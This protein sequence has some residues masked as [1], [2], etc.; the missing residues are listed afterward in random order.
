MTGATANLAAQVLLDRLN[1]S[2]GEIDGRLGRNL[3][4]ALRAFQKS[5]QL[6]ESGKPDPVTLGALIQDTQVAVLLPYRITAE[7]AAG[8]FVPIPTKVAEQAKL[9][10][11]GY[12]SLE[13]AL[14]ERFHCSPALLR[15]LNRG[16]T[17]ASGALIRVPNVP[18]PPAEKAAVPAARVLVSKES[19]L[20]QAFDADGKLLFLAPV[21]SGSE[22]DPLP[23]GSWKVKGV[24]RNP[25]FHYN[26]KLFWDAK[27]TDVK[28]TLPAG[29]NNPVGVVWIE[30]SKE[31]YGLHGTPE[32]GRIGHT[33]SHG[34]VRLT[35]WD[36][37]RLASLV[38]PGTPV[39]F[40]P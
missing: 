34:C 27:A 7:D 5:H 38:A 4:V 12:R 11:M 14:A 3:G 9:P 32:P 37:L 21:S 28:Q 6:L 33:E 15:Q 22:H 19:S 13:E 20:A 18:P 23:I 10:A 24:A 40:E 8:P 36:A 17:F 31:H 25:V 39:E 1:Y 30:V 2:S 16:T 35:N 26:P 29:P